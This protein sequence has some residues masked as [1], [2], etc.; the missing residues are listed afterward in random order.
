MDLG[1]LALSEL[2]ASL[3]DLPHLKALNLRTLRPTEAGDVEW[4]E[5]RAPP[6]LA[7]LSPLAGLQALQSLDLSS[8]GVT[9]LAPLAGLQALQSLNVSSTYVEDLSPLAGLQRLQ[10]L[11]ASTTGVTDLSPL[12][13]LQGLQRLEIGETGVADLAPLAG[14]QGLQSLEIGETN[15]ADLAH[16]A[17]LQ[18]LQSLNL[19]R[20][21]VKDLSPL[22]GLRR[23]QS[24]SLWST[25]VTDLAP[26]A[27]LQELESL[28]VSETGVTDLSPL[29]GLQKLQSLDLSFTGM[30]DLAPLSRLQALQSLD[31][32]FTGV[33]DLAPLAG[34]QELQRLDLQDCQS[35]TDLAPLVGLQ[36]L[37]RLD[38]YGC[39][40][41]VPEKL[42]Q[43][44][45]DHSRLTE[46]VADE[47]VGV[48]R[49]VLSHGQ[50]DNCL[51]RVRTYLS[52]L[53]L[54][55]ET[56][57]EVKVILLGNGR[58]GKSQ[59]CRRFRGQP[60][61]ESIQSTHGV[62]I[63]RE[64]LRI[65]T[66]GQERVFQANWW[67][68]GG[69]DIYHGT[70]A[71]FLRSRAVFL[72]LWTPELENR[73][74]YDENGIPLRNQPLT[75]W[76]DYVRALAG[77]G[78]PVIVV[79]SQCDR[80]ADRRPSPSRPEG[81]GFFEG[82]SYSAKNDLGRDA[83][84]A[85]LRDA[86][87]SLLER[88]GALAIGHGR[89]EVR[90]RLY[91]W[92]SED[93]ER[94][95]EERRNRTLTLEDFRTLCDE[96]G[97]IISWEHAL[98]YFHHTGVVFYRPDLF[99]N[100]IVLDQ[101]WALDAVYTVFHR[102]RT[103]P[104]LRDSGRF[105]RKDLA[106]M[107]WQGHSV[108]EQRLFLALMESCGVCFSCGETTQGEERYIAPDL[109]P[110]FEV[111]ASRLHAWKEEPRTPK[112]RLEYRFFHPAVIRRLMSEIG[113]QAG[114]L[115]E[116]WK[117]GL[118]FKDGR[119]ES[120]LLLQFEDTSTNEA[121]GAGAL[122]LKALGRDPVGLVREIRKAILR[123][124][125]R[126][127]PG[128]LLTL[129]GITVS[130]TAL[131]TVI[132]GRVRDVQGRPVAAAAF[133]AFFEDRERNPSEVREARKTPG[134]DIIPLPVTAS[135]KPQ[136]V[137]ISYAWGDDK[138]PEGKLREQAAEALYSALEQDGFQPE[139][140]RD[141][142]RS[143]E[144]ISAFIRRLTRADLVV[145]VISDKYL[146]SPYCM[147]EIYKLWQRCQGDA[148]LLTRCLVPIVL[149]EVKVGD[150]E[151]R[152]PYL[153]Y[154]STRKANL[155][156][157]RRDLDN[158]SSASVEEIRLV[159]EFAHHVDEILLFLKD[160]LMPNKLEVHFE[161]GFQAV[162]EALRRRT[163]VWPR[164]AEEV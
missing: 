105:T 70:H 42:L 125:M 77:E 127:E 107:V 44:L 26:L 17:G 63:W 150:V 19:W 139:R 79:Q 120:Q 48:P 32:S 34:L 18:G 43:V 21:G 145:A 16:L 100:R 40:P 80:F 93:Q 124:R 112:L 89:A 73:A 111:V 141:H 146:R 131:A 31:L 95:P 64:E 163:G 133:A 35:L 5:D 102:G 25:R 87:L 66:G 4:D 156:A 154:W 152:A 27:G 37:Q 88:N 59:L 78:S 153:R 11:I 151:D 68:F 82:C 39:R 2:P 114:D 137:F 81:L 54:G 46:L 104:W 41:A 132:D 52:E 22:A 94:K 90:R 56:E 158:L 97:D 55:I 20:T 29:A 23:L 71:L 157:L 161:D 49:E 14:L 51:P 140:D 28:N 134:I 147:Y 61:A 117:Y 96:A 159:Q 149:P 129:D 7:D 144:L 121:P 47:A 12:A 67:D 119:K 45:A 24:L 118:W 135:E 162:R 110:K 36:E 6:E 91:A 72:I 160:A 85:H 86:I 10:R 69:Q 116:Y 164:A 126:E 103:A 99:S 109:L 123:R 92:R 13:G 128:E 101:T 33:T 57:N 138:T 155:E 50:F 148:D 130:R 65:Q 108:E 3:R 60:F 74:E 84:E 136:E 83:L 62:Q 38:L 53:K 9:D 1:D 142:M 76:L 115:A 30:T 106:L 143:G 113:R 75:Y 122:E 98:D 15:V 58:V 8:T